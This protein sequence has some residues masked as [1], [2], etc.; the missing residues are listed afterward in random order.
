[1]SA[2]SSSPPIELS[3]YREILER[4][5]QSEQK[6]RELVE[7]IGEVIYALDPTGRLTYVSPAIQAVLGYT[8]AEIVGQSF[9]EYVHED[10]HEAIQRRLHEVFAGKLGP[11]E[12]RFRHR[13]GQVRWLRTSGRPIVKDGVVLGLRGVLVDVTESKRLQEQPA[14][15]AS[16]GHQSLPRGTGRI[17]FVDDEAALVKTAA[18]LLSRLGYDVRGT[19]SGPE[20]LAIAGDPEQAIDLVI[21][22]QTMPEMTGLE[23]A[24]K[25]KRLRPRL[26]VVLCTGLQADEGRQHAQDPAIDALVTKPY[27][28][29]RFAGMIRDLLTRP[30]QKG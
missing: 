12:Y 25:L 13:R 17:L 5:E 14:A 9:L 3:I 7:E 10:D 20:A 23:L 15:L 22:D 16:R 30:R 11:E 24:R 19:S 8:P 18:R 1:M 4:L 29:A 21:T 27:D 6:Y 28:L 26:P 2:T